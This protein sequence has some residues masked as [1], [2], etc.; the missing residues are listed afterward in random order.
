MSD[1]LDAT[2]LIIN[3]SL[4]VCLLIKTYSMNK[5]VKEGISSGKNDHRE[6]HKRID[7]LYQ[8]CIQMLGTRYKP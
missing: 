8:I 5:E 3:F 7:H 4:L 6:L 1:S 2:L